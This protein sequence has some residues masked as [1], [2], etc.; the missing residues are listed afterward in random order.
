MARPVR[1]QVL[2]LRER[3]FIEAAH[4]QGMSPARILFSEILPN[5]V[6][7][8]VVFVPLLVANAILLEAALTFLGA[9][10]QPPNPSWGS[11]ISE[12]VDRIISAPHL[13]IVPGVMLVVTV[14]SLNVL[15][16]AIRGAIDPRA[17]VRIE[18]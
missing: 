4:A 14:L 7:T 3:E 1:G 16:E 15:G 11:M 9:G 13:T 6:P 2:A 12:G 18:H 17:R 5:V 10:I 8:L